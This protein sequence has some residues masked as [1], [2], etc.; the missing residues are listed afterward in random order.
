MS[1]IKAAGLYGLPGYNDDVKDILDAM[2]SVVKETRAAQ[3]SSA[4][5][6]A[7]NEKEV[8]DA[9]WKK[10]TSYGLFDPDNQV[11]QHWLQK[12]VIEILDLYRWGVTSWIADHGSEM[13]FVNAGFGIRQ[14]RNRDSQVIERCI[15][16]KTDINISCDICACL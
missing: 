14:F 10:T 11:D 7:I 6:T 15:H 9:V 16:D 3:I 4:N 13:D 1:A 12:T 2:S 5:S 8:I